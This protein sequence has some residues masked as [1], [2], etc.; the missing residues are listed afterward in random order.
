MKY[1]LLALTTLIA[2]QQFTNDIATMAKQQD[3]NKQTEETTQNPRD[4]Y[5]PY[6]AFLGS[7]NVVNAVIAPRYGNNLDTLN[8]VEEVR[9]IQDQTDSRNFNL[10]IKLSDGSVG[11]HNVNQGPY[12]DHYFELDSVVKPSAGSSIEWA[13]I[14][15]VIWTNSNTAELEMCLYTAQSSGVIATQTCKN[16]QGEI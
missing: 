12:Y 16:F 4:L 14:R 3:Q 9:F 1:S 5:K 10:R 15:N 8:D 6:E 11:D 13:V 7:T 2:C